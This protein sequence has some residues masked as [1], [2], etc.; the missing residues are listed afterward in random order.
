MNFWLPT[1]VLS[2][3]IGASTLVKEVADVIASVSIAVLTLINLY[4][5]VRSSIPKVSVVTFA[6]RIILANLAY[7]LLPL[8]ARVFMEDN[9][10]IP[11]RVSFAIYCAFNSLIFIAVIYLYC[12]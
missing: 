5:H 12:T 10:Q 3:F 8:V 9:T 11:P 2:T 6:E 1:V 4:H 7:S